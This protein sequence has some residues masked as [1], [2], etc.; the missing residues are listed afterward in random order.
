MRQRSDS[1][2]KA[3]QTS[4]QTLTLLEMYIVRS[5]NDRTAL[6]PA[7]AT[8]GTIVFTVPP[9]TIRGV[10]L[11][12]SAIDLDGVATHIVDLALTAEECVS[13]SARLLSRAKEI[14]LTDG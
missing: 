13:L 8:T 11:I 2:E 1:T 3:R 6:R 14:K 10:A 7:S 12:I 5:A 9:H 4:S